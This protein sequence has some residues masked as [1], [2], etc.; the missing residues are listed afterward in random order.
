MINALMLP[1][2]RDYRV[3]TLICPG[4]YLAG[5]SAASCSEMAP[6]SS[7]KGAASDSFRSAIY[8][9]PKEFK[10]PATPGK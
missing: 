2:L 4:P 9:T 5:L 10:V 7:Q 3:Q 1:N 6:A 8:R